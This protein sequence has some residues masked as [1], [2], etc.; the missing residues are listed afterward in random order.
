MKLDILHQKVGT[1]RTG[2]PV[3]CALD[4]KKARTAAAYSKVALCFSADDILDAHA[5]FEYL[6]IRSEKRKDPFKGLYIEHSSEIIK[7]L[8]LGDCT[9]AKLRAGI[10]TVFDLC[11]LGKKLVGIEF[12]DS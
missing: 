9:E 6:S 5:L 3:F 2:K 4:H 7:L 12:N 10:V 11:N 8:S 1:T